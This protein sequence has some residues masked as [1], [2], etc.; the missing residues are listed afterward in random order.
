MPVGR[1]AGS[2]RLRVKFLRDGA[3]EPHADSDGRIQ[4]DSAARAASTM[5]NTGKERFAQLVFYALVLLMG[6]LAYLVISP[7]LGSLAWAA[8]LAM[9]FYRLH[10]RLSVRMGPNRSAL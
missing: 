2:K 3:Q 8:I 4:C 10:L 9:T 1:D 6:Y 7:L 5:P